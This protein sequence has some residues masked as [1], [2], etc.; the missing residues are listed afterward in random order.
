MAPGPHSGIQRSGNTIAS[1]HSKATAYPTIRSM[2]HNHRRVEQWWIRTHSS[3]EFTDSEHLAV[4]LEDLDLPSQL[5][6]FK[7]ANANST[8][9]YSRQPFYDQFSSRV[10]SWTQQH[11]LPPFT[12]TE[13][14]R[15]FNQQWKSHAREIRRTDRFSFQKIKHLQQW[16]HHSAVLHHA[17]HEQAKLTVFCP[18]LYFRGA[19]NTWD[20]QQLFHRLSITP[21]DAQERINTSLPRALQI[22]YKWAINKKSNLPY[23]FVFLKKKKLFLKGRTLISY[24]NSR[25]GRLLQ[26]TARTLDSM[27][28]QLWPQ[29]MG[30]LA[31]P[32]IWS[33][34]HTF[35]KD[36]STEFILDNINDDLVG[37]FNSVPQDRLLDAINS[38]ITEWQNQHDQVTLSV[39]MSQRGN[40]LQ[41]SYVGKFHKAPR[42][43]RV[44]H[45]S[46]IVTIVQSSLQ[47]HI[48][49]AVNVIWT[50][51]EVQVLDLTSARRY[52]IWQSP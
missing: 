50:R 2:L 20:D 15:F 41:L 38:L 9:F 5:I 21:E 35:F 25:Y 39:D 17:D 30:Q 22:K 23:G 16:L 14:W 8:Y 52:P 6:S 42:K 27:L 32:Q 51:S 26:V 24:Y 45:P 29:A 10:T 19:W 37:F 43:T 28:L 36:T 11:G 34:I 44:I 33:R 49:Q 40:P 7:S 4:A 1:S 13:L 3:C 47:S 48:F 12:D 46:D 18:R 31:V